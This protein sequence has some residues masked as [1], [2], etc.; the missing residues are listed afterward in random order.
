MKEQ[1]RR[2]IV[3]ALSLLCT[4]IFFSVGLAAE[5]PPEEATKAAHHGMVRFLDQDGARFPAATVGITDGV[6]TAVRFGFQVHTVHPETL[7]NNHESTL[8]AMVTPTGVWRFLVTADS[9]PAA[10][11]TVAKVDGKWAAVSIGGAGLAKEINAIAD[12]WPAEKGFDI[13]FVRVFQAKTDLMEIR[14]GKDAMGF[15]PFHS[16]RTALGIDS[17]ANRP[18]LLMFESEIKES[19]VEAVRHNLPKDS[20]RIEAT[21]TEER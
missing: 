6:K 2:S 19:L 11:V 14:K 12:A 15:V 16:A 21:E 3:I 13:R 7:M 8:H 1:V 18:D 17:P 5:Q 20:V 9:Q 4:M 10:L